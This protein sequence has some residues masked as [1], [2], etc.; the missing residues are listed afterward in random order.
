MEILDLYSIQI[1]IYTL[2]S[3][4]TYNIQGEYHGLNIANFIDS[5]ATRWFATLGL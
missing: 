2:Q 3:K 5:T 1:A 4:C